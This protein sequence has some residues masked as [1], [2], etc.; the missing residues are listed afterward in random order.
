MAAVLGKSYIIEN[1][2]PLKTTGRSFK[3]VIFKEKGI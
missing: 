2:H 3:N 1:C